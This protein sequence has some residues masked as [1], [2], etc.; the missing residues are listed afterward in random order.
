MLAHATCDTTALQK[1]RKGGNSKEPLLLFLR[2]KVQQKKAAKLDFTGFLR[3]FVMLML[4]AFGVTY[5]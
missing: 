1:K 2:V 5:L 3:C 4:S